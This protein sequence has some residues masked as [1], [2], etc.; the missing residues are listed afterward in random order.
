[1]KKTLLAVLALIASS[2]FVASCSGEYDEAEQEIIDQQSDPDTGTDG[3][4]T[5]GPDDDFG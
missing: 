4:G 3:G 5:S 1:M 2:V